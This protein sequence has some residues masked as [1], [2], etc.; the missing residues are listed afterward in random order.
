MSL[1]KELEKYSV[2]NPNFV[3]MLRLDSTLARIEKARLE[4]IECL[5][6]HRLGKENCS[7]STDRHKCYICMKI[8]KV[9]GERK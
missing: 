7:N 3:R 5:C 9:L 2:E 6:D 1:I 4:L 8:N